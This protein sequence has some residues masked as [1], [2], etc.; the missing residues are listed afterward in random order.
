[1]QAWITKPE[2]IDLWNLKITFELGDDE[3][4]MPQDE[5][6]TNQQHFKQIF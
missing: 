3:G 1:M 5:I 6:I 2:V 4:D